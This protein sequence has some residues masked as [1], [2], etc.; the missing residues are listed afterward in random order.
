M[1]RLALVLSSIV[2]LAAAPLAK[3]DPVTDTYHGEKITDPYRWMEKTG[4]DF[5]AWARA[6]DAQ[7]R[8]ELAALPGYAKLSQDIGAAVEAEISVGHAQRVGGLIYYKKLGHGEAQASL[9]V[10]PLAG[11]AEKR[12]VDPVALGG[13]TT[14]ISEYAV[15]ADN[16]MLSYALS[17]GGSEEAVLHFIDL[18]SGRTLPEAIDRARFASAAWAD[19]GKTVYFTRLKPGGVGADRFS[20]VTVYRHHPGTDPAKDEPVLTASSV[21]SALGRQGFVAV[22]T[23]PG[24]AYAFAAAN[25]GVSPNSEWYVTSAASLAGPGAPH[26]TRIANL[27]DKIDLSPVVHGSTAYLSSFHDAPRRKIISIDLA[28]PDIAHAAMAFAEQTGVAKNMAIA[29]DGIY[30]A[31]AEAAFYRLRRVDFAGGHAAELATPYQG[32]IY[33]LA[34]DPRLPGVVASLVSWVRPNAFFLASGT[35]MRPLA[36]GAALSHGH[37]RAGHRDDPGARG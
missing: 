13:A 20:D 21:G 14:T 15:S 7:T 12:L 4:P 18:R 2:C 9:Y 34:S 36:L 17:S 5:T 1:H 29:A 28:H 32:V 35:G 11:G 22:T 8:G 27:A 24:C 6:Q 31:Y 26:W 16:S 30:V 23:Q 25:S 10:R 3:V 19:D 37:L 33:E